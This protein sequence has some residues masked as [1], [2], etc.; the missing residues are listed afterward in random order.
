MSGGLSVLSLFVSRAAGP[1]EHSSIGAV[2]RR[3]VPDLESSLGPEQ[4][5]FSKWATCGPSGW[6]AHCFIPKQGLVLRTSSGAAWADGPPCI[7]PSSLYPCGKQGG[8]SPGWTGRNNDFCKRKVCS[9]ASWQVMSAGCS[10]VEPILYTFSR[11]SSVVQ[12]DILGR[13]LQA[14]IPGIHRGEERE[15]PRAPS[16]L[17]HVTVVDKLASNCHRSLECSAHHVLTDLPGCSGLAVWWT[18]C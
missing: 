4:V 1:R 5:G 7:S 12:R 9:A 13:N 14:S 10:E 2:A 18:R 16:G 17:I 11:E 6:S 8:L 3:K 15:D